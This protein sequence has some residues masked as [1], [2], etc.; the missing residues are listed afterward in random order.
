M[1]LHLVAYI[2]YADLSHSKGR[3]F[4]LSSYQSVMVD[5]WYGGILYGW[6]S[7]LFFGL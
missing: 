5:S 2:K 6:S 4:S 7:L 3:Q 1:W